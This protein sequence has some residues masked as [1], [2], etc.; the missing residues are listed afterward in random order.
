MMVGNEKIDQV[1]S[2]TELGSIICKEGG[3]TED[4]KSKIAKDQ[5]V[6]S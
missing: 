1:D 4:V 3:Y 6:S 2:F 5:G